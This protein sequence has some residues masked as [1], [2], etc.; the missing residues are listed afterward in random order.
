MDRPQAP[1]VMG[2][3]VGTQSLRARVFDLIGTPVASAEHPLTTT[4]RYPGW[5]C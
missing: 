1:Y 4:Y 3:D 5:A 2:V